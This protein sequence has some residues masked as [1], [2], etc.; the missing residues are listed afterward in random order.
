MYNLE[1]VIEIW[2]LRLALLPRA[3]WLFLI[4][5][6]PFFVLRKGKKND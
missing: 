4:K 3:S 6:K 2:K 5:N 1:S